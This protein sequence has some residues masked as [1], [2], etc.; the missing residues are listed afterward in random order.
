[1][2]ANDPKRTPAVRAEIRS[3]IA[4]LDIQTL[5]SIKQQLADQYAI[6]QMTGDFEADVGA[7]KGTFGGGANL[8]FDMVR[9]AKSANGTIAAMRSMARGGRLV[10]MG[11]METELPLNYGDLLLNNWE[12]IG[13]FMY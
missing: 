9:N 10:L 5:R 6:V 8:V 7:L 12:V 3:P 13:N 4:G 1:M 2:S 11:S